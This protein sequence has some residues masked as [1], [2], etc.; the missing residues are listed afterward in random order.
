MTMP[1]VSL[2]MPVYNGENFIR[3]AIEAIL[4][5]DLADFELII[6]DNAS[7]DATEEICRAYAARDKR[8]RYYRNPQN[9]GAAPNYNRGFELARGTY[10]K[11]CPHDDYMSPNFL[12]ACVAKL[13]ERPDAAL[14]FG[15]T[16]CVDKNSEPFKWPDG[17]MGTIDDPDPANRFYRCITE[18]ATNFPIFG[19]YRV[20]LLKRT[21]LHRSY[22]GSDRALTAEVA[23]LGP[24]LMVPEAIFYNREHPSRSINITDLAVRSRW[25]NGKSTRR[26]A[27]EHVNL[28]THLI[29][30]ARRHP[31]VI[32][33]HRA[34]AALAK[35]A[36]TP[37]QVGRYGLDM[38]RFVS[39]GL[40]MQLKRLVVRPIKRAR[41]E[42]EEME[43]DI[44]QNAQA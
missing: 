3:E 9:L 1:R 5:Q 20:D 34:L 21:T 11:W 15:F 28:L 23:L 18:A 16:Q 41:D 27:M 6:T 43:D 35:Y 39:P 10:L 7:T 17:E 19:L 30:I 4:V 8:V 24:C 25:Q 44:A 2:A 31:D 12:S 22:Y 33:P 36:L 32:A 29:E 37:K 42:S 40:G 38:I 14:A 26:A 13:E